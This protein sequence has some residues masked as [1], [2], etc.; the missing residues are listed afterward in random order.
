MALIRGLALTC[1]KS[2]LSERK[3]YVSY[4]NISS[5]FQTIN[6]GGVPQGSVLGPLLFSIYINDLSNAHCTCCKLTSI[7]FADD[8]SVYYSSKCLDVL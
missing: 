3:K 7:L 8:D 1:F 2:Y 4:N 6:C 5:D